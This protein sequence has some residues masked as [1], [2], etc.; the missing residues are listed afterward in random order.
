VTSDA[1][2]SDGRDECS[3]SFRLGRLI[4]KRS[5]VD[6]RRVSRY[7]APSKN[8]GD[9]SCLFNSWAA[10]GFGYGRR[11]SWVAIPVRNR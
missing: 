10:I 1:H 2:W 5:D 7:S 4:H 6:A 3:V 11:D 8:E 9:N